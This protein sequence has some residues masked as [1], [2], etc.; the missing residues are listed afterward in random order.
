MPHLKY[1]IF[2]FCILLLMG[3]SKD[4]TGPEEDNVPQLY[5][6]PAT[7]SVVI[8]H[9]TELSLNIKNMSPSIFAISLK[10]RYDYTIISFS[11]SISSGSDDFFGDEA[12][13][14]VRHDDSTIYLSISRTQ[15]QSSVGGSGIL[16]IFELEGNAIGLDSIY[17]IPDKLYF[18]DSTGNVMAVPDVE[19]K[20]ATTQC[21]SSQ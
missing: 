19:L 9:E 20:P 17:I 1:I 15:G 7:A 13:K 6:S 10:L 5:F 16:S 14:F 8:G 18:Y 2:G 4:S 12:L 21:V 3:C 11:D